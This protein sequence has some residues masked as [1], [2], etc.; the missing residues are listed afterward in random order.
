[1]TRVAILN[2]RQSKTP[3]GNDPWVKSTVAAAQFATAQGWTV[4]SSI[5]LNTWELVT[6]AVA[7]AGGQIELVL[8]KPKNER[9]ETVVAALTEDFELEPAKTSWHWIESTQ[10]RRSAKSWWADRDREAVDRADMLLPVSVRPNGELSKLIAAHSGTRAVDTRFQVRYAPTANH[11]RTLVDASQLSDSVKAWDGDW[12]IHWTRACHGPWPG[13]TRARFYADL[14]DSRDGY[15]RSALNT[16]RRMLAEKSIRASSWRIAKGQPVIAFTERS[17]YDS[18][19]LMRWRARWARWSFEPY[20]IAISKAWAITNGVRPVR[21][22]TE[23]E[24]RELPAKEKPLCH[25]R[26]ELPDLWPAER[27]WRHRGDLSFKTVPTDALRLIVLDASEKFRLED[28][29]EVRVV[30]F[31]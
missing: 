17:P 11:S 15:C 6:W 16:L 18:L 13:E 29:T 19:P 14:V 4:V 23:N 9:K 20:G 31:T 24:W 28:R 21:Y 5:G 8:P 12:L 22:V 26:G 7:R 2:S 1:M 25:R 3:V 27:E 10:S 30:S